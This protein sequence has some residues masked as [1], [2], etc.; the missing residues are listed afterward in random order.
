MALFFS[1]PDDDLL[2]ELCEAWQLSFYTDGRRLEKMGKRLLATIGDLGKVQEVDTLTRLTAFRTLAFQS[3]YEM[4][5]P[6]E[7]VELKKSLVEA[8]VRN[9]APWAPAGDLASREDAWGWSALA[10]IGRHRVDSACLPA[11]L[12]APL[13]PSL[14]ELSTVFLD[15]GKGLYKLRFGFA[16]KKPSHKSKTLLGWAL[17]TEPVFLRVASDDMFSPA[18]YLL[19]QSPERNVVLVQKLLALGLDPNARCLQDG[20]VP[21]QLASLDTFGV[22]AAAGALPR[23]EDRR[24][25]LAFFSQPRFS[26]TLAACS[27]ELDR[28]VTAFLEPWGKGFW[29]QEDAKDLQKGLEIRLAQRMLDTSVDPSMVRLF[30]QKWEAISGIPVAHLQGEVVKA[31]NAFELSKAK[32]GPFDL[33]ERVIPA[34][35]MEELRAPAGLEFCP[36]VDVNQALA[37]R[38][39]DAVDA[40]PWF[41]DPQWAIELSRAISLLPPS[42]F[43]WRLTS[44]FEKTLPKNPE[45]VDVFRQAACQQLE[46]TLQALLSSPKP[47]DKQK[48][49]ADL[50]MESACEFRQLVGRRL[51]A[52]AGAPDREV[53][54]DVEGSRWA[55]AIGLVLLKG[56]GKAL[57]AWGSWTRAVDNGLLPSEMGPD[58]PLLIEVINSSIAREVAN[59]RGEKAVAQ[60][61]ARLFE[62]RLEP[63][64]STRSRPRM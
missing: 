35:R 29:N 32:K 40:H 54:K 42:P 1:A 34:F 62:V 23:Q 37:L 3:S 18:S 15:E 17:D 24:Q 51:G 48:G 13:A 52:L 44:S 21:L 20:S 61:E 49:L 50:W 36:G 39:A 59:R 53:P 5:V 12:S 31:I 8:F 38:L 57:E 6:P 60:F 2:L 30:F 64:V 16:R 14:A 28:W 46:T 33:K 22:L 7:R 27:A 25:A 55:L 45:V 19:K 9:L 43:A 10:D 58:S 4:H 11:L 56:Q 26:E 63:A 41:D 47:A